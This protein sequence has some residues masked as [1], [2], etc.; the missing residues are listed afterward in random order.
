MSDLLLGLMDTVPLSQGELIKLIRSSPMRYKVYS[1]PKRAPG[2]FRKIAQPAREV[3]ALQYWVMRNVLSKLP[4][5]PAAKAYCNGLNIVDNVR[6]HVQNRFLLKLDF[7]DFFPSIRDNDFKR[8]LAKEAPIYTSDDSELLTS[9]L[10]WKPKETRSLCLAIGAPSS[11]MLSNI[12]L[13]DFDRAV[14]RF[15]AEMDI[16]YTRY[17]DDL[18]FSAQTS[19]LLAKAEELVVELCNKSQSPRLELN[20]EKTVRVS[21]KRARRVTGL[22]LTNDGHVSLGRDTKR[23]IRAGVHHF[24]TNRLS[25]EEIVSLRGTLAYV[26][27]VEPEFVDRLRA[28]YGDEVIRLIQ[29]FQHD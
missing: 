7:K 25:R 27:S 26:N 12:L 18:S 24:V 21:K 14:S 3:K 15:C 9:I 5:H 20:S 16:S 13:C 2:K 19:G 23:E 10:F 1:I 17:A 29:R 4:I 11:P 22:V 28:R 8:F 6:P